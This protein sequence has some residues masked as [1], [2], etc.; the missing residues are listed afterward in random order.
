MRLATAD[1]QRTKALQRQQV[2]ADKAY[3]QQ[4]RS[5]F[6][7]AVDKVV[8]DFGIDPES[9]TRNRAYEYARAKAV[10]FLDTN[11]GAKIEDVDEFVVEHVKDYLE[12]AGVA[13]KVAFSKQSAAK[14][15]AGKQ[16]VPAKVGQAAP[17]RAIPK[18]PPGKMTAAQSLA[19]RR[20]MLG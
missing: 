4:F 16:A 1:A 19:Y 20:K 14:I 5:E 17:P 11:Q 7:D 18:L 10:I 8:K 15:A 3:R 6:S 9:K 12:D 13:K 2:E